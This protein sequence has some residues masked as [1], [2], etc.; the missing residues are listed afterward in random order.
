MD[1]AS[2][3]CS[4]A[5]Q[6]DGSTVHTFSITTSSTDRARIITMPSRPNELIGKLIRLVFT[7][8]GGGKA[9]LFNYKWL[10][11]LEP[12]YLT[13]WSSFEQNYGSNGYKLMKQMWVEYLCAGTIIVTVRTDDGATLYSITLPA[14]TTRDIERFYLPAV[15]SSVLNKSYIYTVDVDSTDTSK[16][17][18]LY[19][20]GTR[21][22]IKNMNGE[23]REAYQQKYVY[24]TMQIGGGEGAS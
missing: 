22:E 4:I 3:A 9:Q 23:Q 5:V 12:C 8:G 19:R 1:T 10:R 21:L 11:V 6:I 14:H 2:V 17:F 24:E 13:H 18:K 16:P 15:S 20:D 7:P